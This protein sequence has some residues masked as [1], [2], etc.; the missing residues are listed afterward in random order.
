MVLAIGAIAAA[1]SV[2][3][4]VA[5]FRTI[6]PKRTRLAAQIVAA[7]IGAVFVIGLQVAAILSYGTLSHIAFLK[8]DTLVALVPALESLVLVAGARRARRS[9]TRS[10][11]CSL[12]PARCSARRS[13]I[14]SARFGEHA[15]AAAGVSAT[16]A[17]AATPRH[18]GFRAA[19]PQQHAAAEGMDAARSAI[20]GS[21]RRP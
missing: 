18:R 11:P 5:L 2:A 16:G 15:I 19:S 1:L 14:F 6:G 20:P 21:P 17:L 13:S 3:L 4:T 12:R 7:V 9:R 8:S 10:P